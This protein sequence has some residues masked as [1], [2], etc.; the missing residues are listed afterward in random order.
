[1][2]AGAKHGDGL[3]QLLVG[4]AVRLVAVARDDDGR[5]VW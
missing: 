4:L 5:A 1:M 3:A 2:P